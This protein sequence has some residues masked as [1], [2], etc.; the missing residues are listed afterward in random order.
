MYG[1]YHHPFYSHL[2]ILDKKPTC[3]I[4]VGDLN[5]SIDGLEIDIKPEKGLFKKLLS[6]IFNRGGK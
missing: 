6:L 3:D 1:A 5:K 4:G 2:F